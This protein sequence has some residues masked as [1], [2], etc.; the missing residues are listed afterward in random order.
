LLLLLELFGFLCFSLLLLLEL[1]LLLFEFILPLLLF[2]LFPLLLLLLLTELLLLLFLLAVLL[3]VI[4]L[5]GRLGFFRIFLACLFEGFIDVFGCGG[6]LLSCNLG[7]L[8]SLISCFHG[9]F[10]LLDLLDCLLGSILRLFKLSL[11]LLLDIIGLFLGLY[12][13]IFALFNEFL[14]LLN[15]FIDTICGILG[16]LRS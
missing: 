2:L 16:L 9:R 6:G 4:V 14:A 3:F 10:S 5:L 7:F 11:S 1:K 13:A 12:E 8:G 15:G